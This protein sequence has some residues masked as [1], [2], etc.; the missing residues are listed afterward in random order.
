MSVPKYLRPLWPAWDDVGVHVAQP[1]LFLTEVRQYR[2]LAHLWRECK[3]A[4]WMLWVYGRALAYGLVGGMHDGTLRDFACWAVRRALTTLRQLPGTTRGPVE[5]A[6]ILDM[7]E[8]QRRGLTTQAAVEDTLWEEEKYVRRSPNHKGHP[9][10]AAYRAFEAIVSSNGIVAARQAIVLAQKL[11][12]YE[13][14][15]KTKSVQAWSPTDLDAL[16]TSSEGSS[17]WV[18]AARRES[19]RQAAQLR[20]VLDNPF[21]RIRSA[22]PLIETATVRP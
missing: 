5:L 11:A 8:R 22:S 3:R 19:A 1:R 16:F 18:A 7:V 12:G 2:S 15:L 10:M 9:Y 6:A 4:E 17:K 13:A 21:V 20:E 14:V